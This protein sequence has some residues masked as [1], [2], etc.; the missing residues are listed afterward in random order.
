MK[1]Y[2]VVF[3]GEGEVPKDDIRKIQERQGV[4]VINQRRERF[5][6]EFNGSADELLDGVGAAATWLASEQRIYT[7]S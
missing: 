3:I 5:L 2:V 6:V 1:R 7:L 4:R